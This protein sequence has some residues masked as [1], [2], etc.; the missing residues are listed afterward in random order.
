MN[1]RKERRLCLARG[2]H[3]KYQDYIKEL[4]SLYESRRILAS[5]ELLVITA[6]IFLKD[7]TT[8]IGTTHRKKQE[9]G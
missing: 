6:L 1:Y 7:A 3:T 8:D 4:T 2:Y 5:W 9:K